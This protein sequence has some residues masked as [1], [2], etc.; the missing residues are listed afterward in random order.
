MKLN[1]NSSYREQ[2]V[3]I[4]FQKEGARRGYSLFPA[5][6]CRWDR[7]ARDFHKGVPYIRKFRR[8]LSERESLLMG[9]TNASPWVISVHITWSLTGFSENSCP[10]DAVDLPILNPK[11]KTLPPTGLASRSQLTPEKPA[12][13]TRI[14]KGSHSRSPPHFCSRPTPCH[15]SQMH[16]VRTHTS[17]SHSMLEFTPIHP[18][19]IQCLSIQ[20][21]ALVET[22]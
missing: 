12:A 8:F 14:T 1:S 9:G 21:T 4:R 2:R 22:V 6:R 11:G 3:D 10:R 5:Q 19:H 18:C 13:S 20:K 17:T 15:I 7:R 16:V